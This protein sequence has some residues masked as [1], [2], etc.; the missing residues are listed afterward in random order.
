ML[1]GIERER[2]KRDPAVGSAGGLRTHVIAA[3]AGAIAV[4]FPGVAVLVAGAV[5]VGALVVVAYWRS[6]SAD[7]G[8]TSEIT[9]FTTYLLGAMAPRLPELAA[10]IGVVMAL[11]LALRSFLRGLVSKALSDREVLDLLLLAAAALVIWPLMPDRSIDRYG[12]INPQAIWELTLLVLLLNAAGYVALRRFGPTRGLPLAGFFGGFVSSAATIAAMGTRSR[13]EPTIRRHALA[14]ALLSSVATPL[15][16]LIM[17]GVIN[18]ELFFV[19]LLP[20]SVMALVAA[21]SAGCWLRGAGS[22]S[23]HV[24]QTFE[25][26]AFQPLQAFVFSITVTSLLWAAAWLAAQFGSLGAAWGVMLGG[27]ADAHSAIASA[28]TLV[29]AAELDAAT[30]VLAIFGHWPAIL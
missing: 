26:R 6:H 17:L 27:F 5:F 14:A 9:L 25:G 19:W 22:P 11:L 28:A 1:I 12:V 7:P 23:D 24:R 21:G 29:R 30:G 10:A 18:R 8:L 16:L 3:L 2:R 4:Q 13:T 15:Q 20:A